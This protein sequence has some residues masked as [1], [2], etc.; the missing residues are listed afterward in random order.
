MFFIVQW[1]PER[2]CLRAL[3]VYNILIFLF[4]NEIIVYITMVVITRGL[5]SSTTVAKSADNITRGAIETAA[6]TVITI[7]LYNTVI[8]PCTSYNHCK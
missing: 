3:K 7:Q 6:A 5:F 1:L 4:C 8:E 2:K